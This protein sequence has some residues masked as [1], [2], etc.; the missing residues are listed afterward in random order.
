MS[1][2]P[3]NFQWALPISRLF[4]IASHLQAKC[5]GVIE[6]WLEKNKKLHFQITSFL[7]STLF[8]NH[9]KR[10]AIEPSHLLSCTLPQQIQIT[11]SRT[12]KQGKRNA[13]GRVE[14]QTRKKKKSIL[15]LSRKSRNF[16]LSYGRQQVHPRKV[17]RTKNWASA[18][19]SNF[20][21]FLNNCTEMMQIEPL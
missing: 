3:Y 9:S 10:S 15:R 19:H 20:R 12:A 4:L 13:C 17:K 5:L 21:T 7:L 6:K 14:R 8:P 1:T 11:S 2:G 16:K 18:Y